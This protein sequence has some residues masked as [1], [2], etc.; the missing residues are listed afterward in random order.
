MFPSRTTS[1]SR[2]ARMHGGQRRVRGTALGAALLALGGLAAAEPFRSVEDF[3]QGRLDASR[4]QRTVDG[5]FRDWSVDVVDAGRPGSPDF[6]LRLRADTRGTRD[7]TVKHLGVRSARPISLRD[8]SRISVRL[9]WGEQA[10]SSYLT[11]AVVLSPHPT[12]GNPLQTSDWLKVAYVGVPPGRNAR[13]V[14]AV[15]S[16]GR[17][18]TVFTEGWPEVN[19]AGRPIGVQEVSLRVHRGSFEVGEGVQRIWASSPDETSFGAGYLYLQMSSHSN[20][21][22][23]SISFD[24]I[25]IDEP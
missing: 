9:H 12:L 24:D 2:Q 19:R 6:R 7:D 21:P 14:I 3:S 10:N 11:G 18:R 25:R 17:E 5:D 23:R 8:G 15:K 1:A 20:Y 13:M 16:Q 4:W 22:A